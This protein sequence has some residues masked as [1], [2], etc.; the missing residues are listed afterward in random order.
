MLFKCSITV[1]V[2][3]IVKLAG[4][5]R[6]QFRAAEINSNNITI[7]NKTHLSLRNNCC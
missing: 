3:L 1:L 5:S 6:S 4:F 2:K 7:I